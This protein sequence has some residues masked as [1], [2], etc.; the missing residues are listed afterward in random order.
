MTSGD[1]GRKPGWVRIIELLDERPGASVQICDGERPELLAAGAD[2]AVYTTE[3]LDEKGRRRT[4]AVRLPRLD[5]APDQPARANRAV[6][7]QRLLADGSPGFEVPEPLAVIR[8]PEG[9]VVVEQRMPGR[10]LAEIGVDGDVDPVATTVRVAAGC[11]ELDTAPF[12]EML[13]GYPTRRDHARACIEIFDDLD[14]SAFDTAKSWCRA[15]LPSAD[16]ARVLHGDLLSQ[17]ILVD[18]RSGDDVRLS[19]VDWDAV[20]LGDPA[21]DLGMVTGGYE[22][23]FGTGQTADDLLEAYRRRTGEAVRRTTVRIY[24]LWDRGRDVVEAFEHDEPGV[25]EIRDRFVELLDRTV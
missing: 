15:H 16:P 13:D 22:T 21:F 5:S 9:L 10:E 19:V 18:L 7:V 8:C 23:V 24:E 2:H 17:N 6:A 14:L 20:R 4:V 12:R 25:D 3:I 1:D 11:H